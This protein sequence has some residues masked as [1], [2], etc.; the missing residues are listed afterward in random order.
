MSELVAVDRHAFYSLRGLTTVSL[1]DNRKLAYIDRHLVGHLV[2]P[3]EVA[4]GVSVLQLHGNNLT[5]LEVPVLSGLEV[6]TL[7]G[8]P[9]DC[10]CHADW[11]RQQVSAVL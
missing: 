10:H 7:Y 5:V 11:I 8:N 3:L 2:G 4:A 9:L 1:H 6:L